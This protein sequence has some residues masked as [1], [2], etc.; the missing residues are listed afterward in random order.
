MLARFKVADVKTEINVVTTNV[1]SF[2]PSL[3]Q[4]EN[5]LITFLN[6]SSV[7]IEGTCRATRHAFKKSLTYA[8]PDVDQTDG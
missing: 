5:T 6:G 1:L 7:V 2:E 3:S 4:P 8:Q